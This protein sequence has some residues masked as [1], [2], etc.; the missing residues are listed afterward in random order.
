MRQRSIN[1]NGA[2][3][4]MRRDRATGL[5]VGSAEWKAKQ[6]ADAMA[7]AGKQGGRNG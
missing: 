7:R 2:M 5:K 4:D 6:I 1:W 3:R